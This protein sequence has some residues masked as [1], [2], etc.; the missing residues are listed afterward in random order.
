MWDDE[1]LF[2][3]PKI[4]LTY[5]IVNLEMIDVDEDTILQN[6]MNTILLVAMDDGEITEDELAILKQVKLDVKSLR[7]KLM[8]IGSLLM[9]FIA[10]TYQA[11]ILYH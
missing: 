2:K 4:Y 3:I 8:E 7:M 6:L 9:E 11:V 5:R 10:V 1:T